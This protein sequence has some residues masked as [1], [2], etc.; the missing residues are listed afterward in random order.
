MGIL[1]K[2][3]YSIMKIREFDKSKE[4]YKSIETIWNMSYPDELLSAIELEQDDIKR[5]KHRKYKRFIAF[6][7]KKAVGFV[8][9]EAQLLLATM[10][11]N[12]KRGNERLAKQKRDKKYRSK[13]E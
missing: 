12:F 4:D 1:E 13:N 10:T 8:N 5:P 7:E 9:F 6:I 2:G 11:G 3:D